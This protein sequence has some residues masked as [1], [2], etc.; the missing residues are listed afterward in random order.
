MLF[1]TV[2]SVDQRSATTMWN[3]SSDAEKRGVAAGFAPTANCRV[4]PGVTPP[5]SFTTESASWFEYPANPTKLAAGFCTK[6]TSGLRT[7]RFAGNVQVS[8]KHITAPGR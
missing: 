5:A 7:A 6:V 1:A 4:S 2:G 8:S 3:V